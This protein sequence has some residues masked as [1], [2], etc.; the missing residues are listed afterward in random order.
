MSLLLPSVMPHVP[1]A[2]A[3][4]DRVTV[5]GT[6]HTRSEEGRWT[7]CAD[8]PAAFTDEEIRKMFTHPPFLAEAGVPLFTPASV[9]ADDP[10]PGRPVRD[11][12]MP[13]EQ[14]RAYLLA[15]TKGPSSNA[16]VP[17]P[18]MDDTAPG[19]WGPGQRTVDAPSIKRFPRD[20]EMSQTETGVIWVRLPAGTGTYAYIPADAPDYAA[21]E[22]LLTAVVLAIASSV[23]PN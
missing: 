7:C 22:P 18:E 9:G 21:I 14:G 16:V 20:W 11:G 8:C 3:A 19:P 1:A 15:G 12:E 17:L 4:G 6:A 5:L 23:T 2:F 13:F 10:L